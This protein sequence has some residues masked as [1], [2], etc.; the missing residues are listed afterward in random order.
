M[1]RTN[2]ALALIALSACS[3]APTPSE[4]QTF[5]T[6]SRT[7]DL[8]RGGTSTTATTEGQLKGD[9]FELIEKASTLSLKIERV[10]GQTDRGSIQAPCRP[11]ADVLLRVDQAS[12]VTLS[13]AVTDNSMGPLSSGTPVFGADVV[14]QIASSDNVYVEIPGGNSPAQYVFYTGG[15][16]LTGP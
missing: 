11:G 4:N 2:V 3:Q 14:A 12:P 15:L 8:V 6:Y 16:D 9:E 13:C 5:W 7:S 1:I 10:A